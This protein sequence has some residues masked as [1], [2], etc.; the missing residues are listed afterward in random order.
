VPGLLPGA[1]VL[2]PGFV[3]GTKPVPRAESERRIESD[4]W[5]VLLVHW[6]AA[7]VNQV[8]LFVR[9]NPKKG[10]LLSCRRRKN[11]WR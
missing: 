8:R 2:L 6:R 11:E 9:V 3:E 10:D 1:T 4:H 5:R 7:L